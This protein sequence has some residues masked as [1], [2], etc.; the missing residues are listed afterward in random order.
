MRGLVRS[1]CYPLSYFWVKY[2][3]S[4]RVMLL[5]GPL[6]EVQELG[7]FAH[8][9][10]EPQHISSEIGCTPGH[11]STADCL[12]CLFVNETFAALLCALKLILLDA[13]AQ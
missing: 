9:E 1:G 6:G 13:I 7:S 2:L 5:H 3:W 4:A 12:Y 8:H 10:A 11:E